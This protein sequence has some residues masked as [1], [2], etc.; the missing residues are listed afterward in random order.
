M[1]C[2]RYGYRSVPATIDSTEFQAMREDASGNNEDWT[3]VEDLLKTIL[4]HFRLL[5]L[6]KES[7]R[8]FPDTFQK[9]YDVTIFFGGKF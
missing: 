3:L 4:T 8:N 7:A 5:T 1:L 2:Q 9:M 6:C